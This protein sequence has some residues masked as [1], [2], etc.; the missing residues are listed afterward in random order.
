MIYF[1]VLLAS[2]YVRPVLG[3]LC[4][5]CCLFVRVFVRVLFICTI[6]VLA[7]VRIVAFASILGVL[8]ANCVV[9]FPYLIILL[10]LFGCLPRLIISFNFSA[11]I[12]LV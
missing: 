6:R 12:C 3:L 5:S 8:F 9:W 4:L 11:E 10:A 1:V 2:V 7:S